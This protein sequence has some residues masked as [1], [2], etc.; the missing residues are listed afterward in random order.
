MHAGM[1]TVTG[2][3]KHESLPLSHALA[4]AM[5][6]SSKC[7]LVQLTPLWCSSWMICL[8]RC[9]KRGCACTCRSLVPHLHLRY[10]VPHADATHAATQY[11]A[12]PCNWTQAVVSNCATS[13]TAC[14][15][16][17]VLNLC[18][19]APYAAVGRHAPAALP[20]SCAVPTMQQSAAAMSTHSLSGGR[21]QHRHAC[22]L[23]VRRG[24]LCMRGCIMAVQCPA[25]NPGMLAPPMHAHLWPWLPRFCRVH[26]RHQPPP[27]HLRQASERAA[28]VEAPSQGDV[29]A[30]GTSGNGI[31]STPC[32]HRA[33][34]GY[35]QLCPPPA[36]P[37]WTAAF[38]HGQAKITLCVPPAYLH[39]GLRHHLSGT[40][41]S[42]FS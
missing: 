18:C 25:S 9:A 6:S 17:G 12:V 14:A 7:W 19:T 29:G 22:S 27:G 30:N 11:Q 36:R 23:E 21:L 42:A 41:G 20:C 3:C 13:S 16:I 35:N 40:A 28:G 34:G 1:R 2:T 4:D 37:L 15:S 5:R 8:T 32:L 31:A 24:A 26:Q 10:T 39:A 38:P 33:V